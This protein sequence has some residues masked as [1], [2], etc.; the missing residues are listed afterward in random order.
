MSTELPVNG[1]ASNGAADSFTVKTGLARMLQ[2][3]VIMDVVDAA[4]VST[5]AAAPLPQ[6]R[7]SN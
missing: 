6:T 1:A 5:A 3:G 4:Q 2:G 7:S